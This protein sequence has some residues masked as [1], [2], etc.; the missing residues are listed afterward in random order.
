MQQDTQHAQVSMSNPLKQDKVSCI[1][2]WVWF[3]HCQSKWRLCSTLVRREVVQKF[4]WGIDDNNQHKSVLDIWKFITSSQKCWR[5]EN[6]A[7]VHHN[8]EFF[9]EE[10]IAHMFSLWSST[11]LRS[12]N[13]RMH[14]L[15][16]SLLFS[17][18]LRG[19]QHENLKKQPKMISISSVYNVIASSFELFY[20]LC[21]AV[22]IV[23]KHGC[24]T[25]FH[26]KKLLVSIGDSQ[27]CLV[28]TGCARPEATGH[29]QTKE[30]KKN[31]E[32]HW[33]TICI[34][35]EINV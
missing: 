13:V 2:Q 14:N 5:D 15:S 35:R 27:P 18:K 20:M 29:K 6:Y 21:F 28:E 26:W 32:E 11:L 9:S 10:K 23:F 19:Q 4:K 24:V 17:N 12:K 1:S 30:L 34:F 31:L 25:N 3:H 8:A 22:N 7:C 16:L 33:Q